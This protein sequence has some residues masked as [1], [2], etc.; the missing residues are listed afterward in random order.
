MDEIFDSGVARFPCHQVSLRR[1]YRLEYGHT[2]D[3]PRH[4]MQAPP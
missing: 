3:V 1:C 4:L 2:A